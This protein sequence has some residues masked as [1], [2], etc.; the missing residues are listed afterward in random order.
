MDESTPSSRHSDSLGQTFLWAL[1]PTLLLVLTPPNGTYAQ[2]VTNITPT[3]TAPLDLGTDVNTVGTTTEITGGTRPNNGTNLFH[4]FD[5]FTLGT[6]DTAHFL[7]DMQLPTNNIFGR[8]IGGEVSTIDGTLQ[9]NNPLNAADPMNFGAANLWLVNPSGLLLGPN[10]R[11]DVGGSV[12]MSTANYLR[13]DGTSTLFDMLSSPASLGPL[14]VAPVVAF[15]FVGSNPGDITVQGSQ[16][17]VTDGQ[18]ISLVGGNVSIESGTAE[19]E[20]D[21]PVQLSAPNGKIQLA[22]AASTGE[23][24]TATLQALP[25]ADSTSFTSFGSVSL[26]PGSHINVS[27]A[28]TVFI[29]GGQIVLS[30]NDAVLTTSQT[31]GEP[32]TISLSQGSSIMT[33]NSGAEP[34]ADVQITV[35][36][37]SLDGAGTTITTATFGDGNGGNIT[38]NV[39]TLSVTN[40]AMISSNN[41]SL[42]LA[43]GG[44]VTVQGLQG[45]GSAAD[46][47]TLSNSNAP[48][49]TTLTAFG[50]GRGG[51]VRITADT[52]MIENASGISTDTTLGG[53]V[54]GD[55]SLNIGKLTLK[56]GDFGGSA[57]LTSNGSGADLD[58]D[59][60]LDIIGVGGN[61][62]IQGIDGEGSVADSVELS[63]GSRIAITSDVGDGGQ[64]SIAAKSL[65]LDGFDLNG[66]STTI[67]STASG[68]GHGGS[69]VVSVGEAS[70]SGGATITS[71]SFVDLPPDHPDPTAGAGGSVTVQGPN[72]DGSKADSLHLAGFG[73]G[74]I[75]DAV[76]NAPPG[77]IAVHARTVSLMDRAVIEGGDPIGNGTGGIVTIDADSVG[78]IGGSH[79]SS[80]A[81][82][83]D[84]GQ[85]TITADRLTLDN[86]SIETNSASPVGGRAGDVLLTVGNVSL[87]N[88][89]T[90]NSSASETGLAG[91]I[92]ILASGS[93]TMSN[94][95]TI[96]AS[97]TGTA[98][99]G[100]ITI[101]TGD[102][103]TMTNSSVTTEATEASGGQIEINA[104]EMVRLINSEVS[105]S[106]EGSDTDTFGG[107]ILI[108]PQFVILQN[109]QV[110]AQANAGT[111]GTINIIAGVFVADPASLVSASAK[112]GNSGTVSIQSPVQNVS[113]ELTPMSQEFSSAAGL[114]AQQCAA[115]I[116]DGK[117]STF[118]V[119]GREGLPL[120]PG[121]F[122]ASPTLTPEVFGLSLSERDLLRPIAPIT[123]TF[124]EYNAR[125]IQLAKYGDACR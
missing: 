59:G 54:G 113:G 106:V 88:G 49:I 2:I 46:L 72:G 45:L 93:V 120:E 34:G 80:Q 82:A 58:G 107:T 68:F 70:L 86:G 110:T 100:N 15:G 103:F 62:T 52:L 109:S 20:T 116:A 78:I 39:E 19:G 30:V 115:R 16:F 97:S 89:A 79:I 37:L 40:G 17:S 74:I 6:G 32:E 85:V 77:D 95:S 66:T 33:S 125:P 105:T 51:D 67:N 122:L 50:L 21:Q 84:A 25:N 10:V 123:R 38:A 76:G 23:F 90:I 64:L 104:P 47:V 83:Q 101:N 22:S 98:N 12:S 35:G 94:G 73:S 57:I 18:S 26:A 31:S 53:G 8:V 4:S 117:F 102:Q 27:G 28:S 55:L 71:R 96:S 29:K 1:I 48:T 7:N 69:M 14:S 118:V 112:S 108:D 63:G 65:R 91:E 41:F 92:N 119:A 60:V 5:F 9:T 42:G 43:A 36:N 81:R 111:G 11:I 124:Q 99:A 121:G 61:V 114:L 56:G 24:D 44:N 13:F 75:S 87:S 3:Q